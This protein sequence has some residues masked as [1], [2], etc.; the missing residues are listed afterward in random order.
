MTKEEQ[1]KKLREATTIE[2]VIEILGCGSLGPEGW[3][4]SILWEALRNEKREGEVTPKE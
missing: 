3:Y 2:Q 1:A 4:V